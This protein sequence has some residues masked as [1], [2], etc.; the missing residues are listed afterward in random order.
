[1]F[2]C[3]AAFPRRCCARCCLWMGASERV[4]PPSRSRGA[5]LY[6]VRGKKITQVRQNE[7]WWRVRLQVL[8]T[9]HSNCRLDLSEFEFCE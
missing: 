3:A 1:M 9:Q 8:N 6:V 5:A 4:S 7:R 2:G